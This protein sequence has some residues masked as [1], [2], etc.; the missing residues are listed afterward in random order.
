MGAPGPHSREGR[1]LTP[2]SPLWPSDIILLLVSPSARLSCPLSH[3]RG[4]ETNTRSHIGHFEAAS[5]LDS[6]EART[7]APAASGCFRSH[8]HQ[9][10]LPTPS[11][12][13]DGLAFVAWFPE[14][15]A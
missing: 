6:V 4:V 15:E 11:R 7:R 10:Y 14:P 2:Q 13:P 12:P 1:L 3:S 9:S 5:S 8:S